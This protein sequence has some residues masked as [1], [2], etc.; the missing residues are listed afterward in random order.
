MVEI[1]ALEITDNGD[2]LNFEGFHETAPHRIAWREEV[3]MDNYMYS[4]N[5]ENKLKSVGIQKRIAKSADKRFFEHLES[6]ESNLKV[7]EYNRDLA[8]HESVFKSLIFPIEGYAAILTIGFI[9]ACRSNRNN[10]FDPIEILRQEGIPFLIIESK[11]SICYVG[12]F[13]ENV[14][15][16]AKI[17]EARCL[18]EEEAGA[19]NPHDNDVDIFVSEAELHIYT[20]P[21]SPIYKLT[22]ECDSFL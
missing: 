8:I 13:A 4:M 7:V 19:Y 22:K 3:V 20:R 2:G 18:K 5:E 11:D 17:G 6:G 14:A 9:H 12:N 10:G 15:I 1:K 21:L 16:K